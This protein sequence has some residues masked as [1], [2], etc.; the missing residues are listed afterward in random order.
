MSY[1]DRSWDWA[2]IAHGYALQVSPESFH[3]LQG[4][5]RT[6][7]EGDGHMAALASVLKS[8][9]GPVGLGCSPFPVLGLSVIRYV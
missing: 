4:L 8:S 9:G 7:M 6:R 1:L 3:R 2:V 5:L